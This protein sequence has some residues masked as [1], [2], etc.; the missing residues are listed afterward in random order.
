MTHPI[1]A[2]FQTFTQPN[3]YIQGNHNIIQGDHCW[4]EGN[5]NQVTGHQ[6]TV[7]GR[8]N[9]IAGDA[10]RVMGSFNQ[11]TGRHSLAQGDNN[12]FTGPYSR[13]H[14]HNNTLS[15]HDG[16]AIGNHNTLTGPNSRAEGAYNRVVVHHHNN[17][18]T[19]VANDTTHP[20]TT[21]M[22]LQ[23]MIHLAIYQMH[24]QHEA[25]M[26]VLRLSMSRINNTATTNTSNTNSTTSQETLSSESLTAHYASSNRPA[27]TVTHRTT[28]RRRRTT[29]TTRAPI[30]PDADEERHDKVATPGIDPVCIICHENLPQCAAM[31]CMH[32]SYCIACAR[33]MCLIPQGGGTESGG[34][35]RGAVIP[36]AKCRQPI[37]SMRRFFLES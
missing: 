25:L 11:L 17:N 15:G 7:V 35:R 33:A 8:S 24:M 1:Q 30:I 27:L 10:S 18:T 4:V 3:L 5:F 6:T 26:R 21:D 19:V 16:F 14:G 28:N 20:N 2:S 29:S 12:H 31:P 36:C 9:I 32:L 34:R 23:A 37:Q 22:S 13:A